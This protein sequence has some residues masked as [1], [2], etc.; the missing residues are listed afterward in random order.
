LKS[1]PPSAAT[2]PHTFAWF[3][4]VQRFQDSVRTTWGGAAPAKAAQK[5]AAAKEEP[6][7]EVAKTEEPKAAAEED[8]MDLFGDDEPDEVSLLFNRNLGINN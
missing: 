1:A 3:T 4:L 5:P 2:H 8:D 6:K 7:K